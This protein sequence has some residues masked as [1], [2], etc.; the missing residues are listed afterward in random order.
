MSTTIQR[1]WKDCYSLFITDEYVRTRRLLFKI[2][3]M[4]CVVHSTMCVFTTRHAKQSVSIQ[5]HQRAVSITS[6]IHQF[7]H[8]DSCETICIMF[9]YVV[10]VP[11][12]AIC[13]NLSVHVRNHNIP[14][15]AK[16]TEVG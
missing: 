1:P 4:G 5:P 12:Y 7:N 9:C 10:K 16:E 3:F 2:S 6:H 11:E 15:A 13:N 8:F 14:R